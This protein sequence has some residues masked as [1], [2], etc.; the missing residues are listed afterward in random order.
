MVGRVGVA[1]PGIATRM[2]G[3]GFLGDETVLLCW[4]GEFPG[5]G[6]AGFKFCDRAV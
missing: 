3:A 6:G 4:G 2:L 5:E 1:G